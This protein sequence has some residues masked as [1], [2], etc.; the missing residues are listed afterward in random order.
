MQN[1]FCQYFGPLQKIFLRLLLLLTMCKSPVI[2]WLYDYIIILL[3]NCYIVTW[4]LLGEISGFDKNTS[5]SNELAILLK[6]KILVEIV[7]TSLYV[8]IG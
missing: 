8:T 1:L 6:L 4:Y 2:L 5:K 7:K 3:Y